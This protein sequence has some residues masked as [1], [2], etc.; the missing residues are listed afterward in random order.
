[1]ITIEEIVDFTKD[2]LK[3]DNIFPDTDI[4]SLGVCGDDMDEFLE[5]YH[6]KY[7]V[8]FDNY[9]WYFHNEEEISNNFSIGKIFFKPPYDSVERIPITPE[10]LTKFANTKVW[11][12]DYPEHQLPKYRYDVLIDQIIFGGL[13]LIILYFSFKDCLDKINPYKTHLQN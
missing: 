11:E 12:I 1:M 8:N 10:I 9:L 4:F 2:C 5:S 3:E 13:A 7:N 6:K